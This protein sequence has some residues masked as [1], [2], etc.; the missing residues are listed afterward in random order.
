MK[1]LYNKYIFTVYLTCVQ[2]NIFLDTNSES[3]VHP[4]ATSRV[5][6][7]VEYGTTNMV[8]TQEAIQEEG[9]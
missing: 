4:R 8:P 1:H 2:V 5:A 7:S 9:G 6:P 3:R